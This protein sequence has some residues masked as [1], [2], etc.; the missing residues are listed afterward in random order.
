MTHNMIQTVAL[1]Q[2]NPSIQKHQTTTAPAPPPPTP[3][4]GSG[5]GAAGCSRRRSSPLGPSPPGNS[6]RPPVALAKGEGRQSGHRRGITM[7]TGTGSRGTHTGAT[8]STSGRCWGRRRKRGRGRRRRG[9]RAIS[10]SGWPPAP[11]R[12]RSG[13]RCAPR[14]W[15]SWRAGSLGVRGSWGGGCVGWLCGLGLIF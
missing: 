11:G 2:P 5:A 10:S 14:G 12:W 7:P 3:T 1:V 15:G 9:R 13:R 4:H 6:P 8:S